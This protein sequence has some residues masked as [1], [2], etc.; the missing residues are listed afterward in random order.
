LPTRKREEDWRASLFVEGTLIAAA[1]EGYRIMSAD[2]GRLA[3]T[4]LLSCNTI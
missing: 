2:H 3:L 1:R 4:E